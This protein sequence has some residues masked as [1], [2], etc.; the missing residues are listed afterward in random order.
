MNTPMTPSVAPDMSS[1]VSSSS[2]PRAST[3]SGVPLQPMQLP[4]WSEAHND[5][6]YLLGREPDRALFSMPSQDQW[7]ALGLLLILSPVMLIRAIWAWYLTGR[8]FD[9]RVSRLGIHAVRLY[10]FSGYRP[11]RRLPMLINVLLKNIRL[12]GEDI[13]TARSMGKD[14]SCI[15][16][17]QSTKFGLVSVKAMRR[18]T[19]T[20]Y[21]EDSDQ[22]PTSLKGKVS[23]LT[24]YGIARILQNTSA[25]ARPDR[26]SLLGVDVDNVS[27]DD[28][29]SEIVDSA[30]Q[31][32]RKRYAFV[33][34]D[35]LNLATTHPVYREVLSTK[36]RVFAD[37]IGLQV[38]ARML[39]VRLRAN[40]NGT[41]M[42]PLLCK[43]CAE[44]GQSIYFL[45]G[46]PGVAE[47][48]AQTLLDQFPTLSVAGHQ[49]GYFDEDATQAVIDDINASGAS[50]L[51]V[52]MGAPTQE[53]WL[54][55]WGDRLVAPVAMGVGGLFDFYSGRISRC[56]R[57]MQEIGM[58]WIWR[59]MQEPQRMWRRYVLGNPLFLLRVMKQKFRGSELA[60]NPRLTRAGFSSAS[61]SARVHLNRFSWKVMVGSMHVVKRAIDICVSSCALLALAPLFL[62][63]AACVKIESRGPVFFV[64]TRVGQWGGYFKMF[65]FRSMYIDAEERKQALMESNEMSGGVTFKMKSDPRITRS[66]RFLRKYSIDELPQLLNVLLGDMSLVGPRPPV[67]SEVD[68]YVL[69]DRRRLEVKPGITCFWQV[70]GRSEIPF[71]EQVNLDIDYIESQSLRQDILILLR[72][73]PAVL[74]GKGAY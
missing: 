42:L 20:D 7:I 60:L 34:P 30:N 8:V 29:V 27:L 57:W 39:G 55:T 18:M 26:F 46:R 69:A 33:N 72:T 31:N 59:L 9:V 38:A 28:A 6:H 2:A 71:A 67:P 53:L 47:R 12:I 54:S 1:I 68:T 66:G 17:R 45:G 40:V 50:I 63:V 16:P 36:H 14:I 61:S 11:G 5:A 37:G 43:A 74:M 62:I 41:D 64:Q 65:K 73:I 19:G 21:D 10:R 23:L 51:L 49:H 3:H 24:R 44:H 35:C 48:A 70:S 22:V 25:L 56:P 32:A 52:A 58:E 13:D 4:L 15:V